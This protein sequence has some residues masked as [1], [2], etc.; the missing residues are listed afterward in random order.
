MMIDIDT[1][2]C[3]DVVAEMERLNFKQ[4]SVNTVKASSQFIDAYNEKNNVLQRT[5]LTM[6]FY[7][8]MISG[9]HTAP[10]HIRMALNLATDVLGWWDDMR[11]V[12]LPF[13][14]EN[15]DM[16]FFD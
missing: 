14:K 3:A 8:V 7:N 11:L 10:A 1:N 4:G 5:M 13:L 6:V 16:F 12:I 2:L 9:T 15:E